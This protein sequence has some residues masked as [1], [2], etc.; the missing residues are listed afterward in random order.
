[1]T[2]KEFR[3]EENGGAAGRSSR[4]K[5]LKPLVRVRKGSGGEYHGK[6]EA[7]PTEYRGRY[8]AEPEVYHGKHEAEPGVYHGKHE[9]EPSEYHGKHEA[10]P[11]VYHGKHEAEPSEYHGRHE[12]PSK[13]DPERHS[14]AGRTSGYEDFEEDDDF[15]E[16]ED[17]P[18]KS[19]RAKNIIIKIASIA[20]TLVVI[21]VLVLNV[22]ICVDKDTGKNISLV[23]LFKNW[24]PAAKEGFLDKDNVVLNKNPEAVSD[25]YN[26][27]LDLPQ[28]IE[29]QYTVLF[30]GFEPDEYNTDIMWVMQ[31]DIGHGKL[32]ILQIPRDTCLPDYTS[33]V[34][35]KFNSIYSMGN[36]SI[37]PPIQRTVNAVQENFGIPIDAY[38]TTTCPDIVKIID[39]IGGVPISIENEIVFEPGKV[40]PAGDVVLSGEQSEWFI[41]FRREWLQGDIGRMQNQRRFM[42]AAMKKLNSI[43]EDEGKVKLYS[44]IKEIYDKDLLYTDLSVG[45][46]GKLADFAATISMENAV[47]NMVPGEDASFYAADGNVYSVYSVHKQATIDLLNKYYR[48]YQTDMTEADTSIVE[49]V[50]DYQYNILD[51]TGASFDDIEDSTEPIRNPNVTPW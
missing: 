16:D 14:Y 21:C 27:G 39:L 29:G 6:H 36:Q 35:R 19:G 26:D 15:Y 24:Q 37:N 32:N 2:D 9:A 51:D 23:T 50:T 4:P 25:D 28:L 48:P 49:L 41:R 1:M 13:P 40:I 8:E 3:P 47:V 45:D 38:V 42:A 22:P 44:Y 12:A 33:S 7:Q 34:T 20:T 31:F 17:E 46:I 18:A 5:P 11:A 43:V 10:E 30:L